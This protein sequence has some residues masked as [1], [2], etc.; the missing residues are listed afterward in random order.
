M[1]TIAHSG[2]STHFAATIAYN[3][4]ARFGTLANRHINDLF[5]EDLSSDDH[6]IFHLDEEITSLDRFVP[7]V[8]PGRV[9]VVLVTRDPKGFEVP[10]GLTLVRVP[11]VIANILSL[12]DDVLQPAA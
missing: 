10:E 3:A 11:A 8:A 7:Y 4:V 9:V 1:L 5:P 12:F 2:D 6:L